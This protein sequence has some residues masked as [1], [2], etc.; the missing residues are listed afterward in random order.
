MTIT[1]NHVDLPPTPEPIELWSRETVLRFFGGDKPIH[2]STLY[3]GVAL[4][5]YPK[6]LNV[7]GGKLGGAVR[8]VRAECE[9]AQRAMLAKRD[10]P[11]P[12]SRRGRPRRR[13]PSIDAA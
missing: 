3:R 8:W 13:I 11:K 1:T 5:I 4:G 2:Q 12:K 7:S 9:A 6:P 10:E